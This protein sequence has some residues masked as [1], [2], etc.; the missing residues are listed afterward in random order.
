MKKILG[1]SMFVLFL[2]VTG[3]TS[4][5]Q[6]TAEQLEVWAG[7]EKYWEISESD[8][9]AFL[10]YFD[11]SYFGWSYSDEAPETK[12]DNVKSFSYWTTKGKRQFYVLTPA[13]IW[14]NGNFAFVHYYYKEVTESS[15]G[16]PDQTRGRWTDILM[17]KNGKWMLVGDH[18]GE[19]KK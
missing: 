4:A 10:D 3:F 2:F 13:K 18:G 5:Q 8:P 1:S 16:K 15:K 11:D 9:L 6:W 19:V 17:K 12:G 14:V 7:V